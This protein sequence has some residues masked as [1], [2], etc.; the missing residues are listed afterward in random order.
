MQFIQ[1]LLSVVSQ[2]NIYFINN[3]F[4][5]IKGLPEQQTFLQNIQN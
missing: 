3:T 5:C 1:I 4:V 2:I